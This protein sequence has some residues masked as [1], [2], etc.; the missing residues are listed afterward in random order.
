MKNLREGKSICETVEKNLEVCYN[1]MYV[2]MN[3]LNWL[4]PGGLICIEIILR[5]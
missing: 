2:K 5:L 3:S 4:L 1:E